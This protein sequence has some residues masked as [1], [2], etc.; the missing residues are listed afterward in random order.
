MMKEQ[1]LFRSVAESGYYVCNAEHCPKKA[2]CLRWIVGQ[3]MS[4]TVMFCMSA[5]M[6]FKDVATAQCPLF[7][8]AEK[9]QMAKGMIHIF[10]DNMPKR[11]ETSLRNQLIS[12]FGRTYYYEYRNGTRLIAPDMQ[13]EIRQMFR[14]AG[15]NEDVSFDEYV[16]DYDW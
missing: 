4:D 5:N 16:K 10:S 1:E 15:W 9:A 13:E 7:R 6:R 14:Q 12:R 3:H 2:Q 11:L 8:S